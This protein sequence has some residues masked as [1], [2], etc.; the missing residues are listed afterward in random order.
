MKR[1]DFLKC[2]AALAAAFAVPAGLVRAAKASMDRAAAEASHDAIY[3]FQNFYHLVGRFEVGDLIQHT[4]LQADEFFRVVAITDGR[5]T[6]E[7]L[8]R[9]GRNL[10]EIEH[11]MHEGNLEV[12]DEYGQVPTEF[13]KVRELVGDRP[14]AAGRGAYA[15]SMEIRQRRDA[16]FHGAKFHNR[17]KFRGLSP[18]NIGW[19]SLRLYR[20]KSGRRSRSF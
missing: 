7:P 6:V 5:L 2:G 18:D 17:A 1:R 4:H 8:G 16:K 12:F 14:R 9:F 10:D 19:R 15:R 20:A 11:F 3:G 13:F